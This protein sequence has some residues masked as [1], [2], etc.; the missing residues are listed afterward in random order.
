MRSQNRHSTAEAVLLWQVPCAG[1]P[2]RGHSEPDCS[3]ADSEL[4]SSST[5]MRAFPSVI[6]PC[7]NQA[8][9]RGESFINYFIAVDFN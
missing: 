4:A 1:L 7:G 9:C 8:N 3:P 2:G 6:H 5:D